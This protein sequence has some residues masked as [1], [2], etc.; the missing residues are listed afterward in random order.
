MDNNEMKEELADLRKELDEKEEALQRDLIRQ[1]HRIIPIFT[2]LIKYW[3][4]DKK[5]PKR[6]ASLMAF[7]WFWLSPSGGAAI[8]V[9]IFTL[10]GI[11]IAWQANNLLGEQNKKI[12]QQTILLKS[13]T[14][15]LQEQNSSIVK[16]TYLAESGRRSALIFELSNILDNLGQEM[17]DFY[18]QGHDLK[19]MEASIYEQYIQPNGKINFYTVNQNEGPRLKEMSIGINF[20]ADNIGEGII[21][22]LKPRLSKWLEGRI[23]SLSRALAPYHYL[24]L[25]GEL[26]DFYSSPERGQLL[27]ALLESNVYIDDLNALC[28]FD[29]VEINNANFSAKHGTFPAKNP[30]NDKLTSLDRYFFNFSRLRKSRYRDD[31]FYY[32]YFNK[33]S[34]TL[35]HYENTDF[36]A[37]TFKAVRFDT[38]TFV[39]VSFTGCLTMPGYGGQR[40]VDF[41]AADMRN[42][43]FE[44]SDLREVDFTN[45]LMENV[46]F[47]GSI[48]PT[49]NRPQG[50]PFNGATVSKISFDGALTL[51]PDCLDKL[52][53]ALTDINE[54]NPADYTIKEMEEMSLFMAWPELSNA[55]Q[56]VYSIRKTAQ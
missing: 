10:F 4:K 50:N 54:Y 41:N 49:M 38:A 52:Q 55:K 18:A 28:D 51:D 32:A 44:D 25:A 43:R 21:F 11:Y 46:Q 45:A 56:K 34:L 8:G 39:N 42:V 6:K 30:Y 1:E 7:L 35:A 16:Q 9:T 2:N 24:N 37:S 31:T 3:K 13:Q 53:E 12:S 27:I 17:H 26:T 19:K 20:I 47:A 22:Q 15:L 14:N 29:F 33:V 23:I 36:I 5:D 40:Y 48:L